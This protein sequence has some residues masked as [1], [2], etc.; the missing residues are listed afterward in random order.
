MG[1]NYPVKR[2]AIRQAPTWNALD[3]SIAAIIARTVDSKGVLLKA[4]PA[5]CINQR[6]ALT[7]AGRQPEVVA[8]SKHQQCLS[9]TWHRVDNLVTN[10]CG[11]EFATRNP[12]ERCNILMLIGKH[13]QEI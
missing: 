8:L 7:N 1:R 12:P 9:R 11:S 6:S 13:H 5:S 3:L 2:G 4:D 10:R